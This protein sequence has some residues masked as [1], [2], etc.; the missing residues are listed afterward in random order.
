LVDARYEKTR[1]RWLRPSI[2]QT[3]ESSTSLNVCFKELPA[4]I[5]NALPVSRTR[6]RRH[7]RKS[8]DGGAAGAFPLQSNNVHRLF[9]VCQRPGQ[10]GYFARSSTVATG[11]AVSAPAPAPFDIVQC[12]VA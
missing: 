7:D 8:R 2:V 1:H 10:R 4:C 12:G 5:F 3:R 9:V 11:G 6:R